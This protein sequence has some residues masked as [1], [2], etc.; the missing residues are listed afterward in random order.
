MP[1]RRRRPPEPQPPAPLVDLGPLSPASQQAVARS[2]DARDR[3]DR[4]VARVPPGPLRVRL[5]ELSTRIEAGVVAAHRLASRADACQATLD[6]LRPDLLTARVKDARRALSAA[7]AA[8]VDDPASRATL[9]GLLA[10]LRS[11]MRV[12]DAVDDCRQRLDGVNRRLDQAVASAAVVA[13]T[14]TVDDPSLALIESDLSAAG[15][16]LTALEASLDSLSGR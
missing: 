4:I 1:L 16:E 8:G 11:T 6:D 7:E 15:E 3:F 10:Q 5:E 13:T 9:D 12:W 14:G 2:L